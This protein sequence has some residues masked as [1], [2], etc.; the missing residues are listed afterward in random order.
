MPA[1]VVLQVGKMTV[2]AMHWLSGRS[3]AFCVARGGTAYSVTGIPVAERLGDGVA[4]FS[5]A[6]LVIVHWR[7]SV[8][9]PS[10]SKTARELRK[11][12]V[13]LFSEAYVVPGTDAGQTVKPAPSG[14]IPSVLNRTAL[15]E[16]PVS[17]ALEMP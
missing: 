4:V 14:P 16:P 9:R 13:P 6:V 11:Y 15:P 5:D 17:A 8:L 1:T 2:S 3:P 12:S 10:S 7:I